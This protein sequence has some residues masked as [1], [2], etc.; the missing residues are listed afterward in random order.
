MNC[1]KYRVNLYGFAAGSLND[2]E[3]K[4]ILKHLKSCEKCRKEVDEIRDIRRLLKSGSESV[5]SPQTDLKSNI[6]NSINLKKY[7]NAYKATLGELTNWGMSL[8]AA[9]LILLFI[10]LSPTE[11]IIFQPINS[12]NK[13]VGGFTEKIMELDGISGRIERLIREEIKNEL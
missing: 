7:K 13:S 8:V 9:G 3:N 12:I 10:N 11:K 6:M 2:L 1:D 4:A 5:V